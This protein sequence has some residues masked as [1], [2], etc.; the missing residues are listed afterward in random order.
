MNED[1]LTL[2]EGSGP[3]V[4]LKEPEPRLLVVPPRPGFLKK[5]V[6]E[7]I[8]W[9]WGQVKDPTQDWTGLCQ[10]FC[11][12]SYGVRAW[13]PSAIGAWKRIPARHKH[14]GGK[15]EDAPRGALIY[16]AGGQFGHVAVAIGKKTNNSCLSNDY[17]K[18][19]AINR[20]PREF[21]RWGVRYLGWSAWTPFG[22]MRLP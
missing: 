4:D 21:P 10:S 13:S 6:D 5:S 8:S 17:V 2:P 15:P 11:R 16:F 19:G 7:A 12:Q 22:S 1:A 20:A 14:A 3:F 18:R 9:A